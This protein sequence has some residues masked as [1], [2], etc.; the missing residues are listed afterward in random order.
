MLKASISD[1]RHFL[2]P[3]KGL[4]LLSSYRFQ[5][6]LKIW[7]TITLIFLII[8][9]SALHCH[10]KEI[11]HSESRRPS[12]NWSSMLV[13]KSFPVI[14][15]IKPCFENIL[16]FNLTDTKAIAVLFWPLRLFVVDFHQGQL[17]RLYGDTCY[18]HIT[19]NRVVFP[20]LSSSHIACNLCCSKDQFH[21]KWIVDRKVILLT[22][23]VLEGLNLF[24]A[25]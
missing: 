5:T 22:A 12:W 7:E 15:I 18:H 19:S 6:N 11:Y 21:L 3:S 10:S 1:D 20:Y 13:M 17:S 9:V 4:F 2:L 24:S 8:K 14:I 23:L 16:N 25:S